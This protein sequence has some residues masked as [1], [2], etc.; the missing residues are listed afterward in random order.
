MPAIYRFRFGAEELADNYYELVPSN[1]I[2]TEQCPVNRWGWHQATQLVEAIDNL[3]I[4][5]EERILTMQEISKK[6]SHL[7]IG[8]SWESLLLEPEGSSYLMANF[9]SR[10]GKLQRKLISRRDPFWCSSWFGDMVRDECYLPAGIGT[11]ILRKVEQPGFLAAVAK[12]I[13]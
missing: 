10:D 12:L 2:D 13:S 11:K 9:I 1:Q 6:F 4:L 7:L 5:R 3:R 8:H